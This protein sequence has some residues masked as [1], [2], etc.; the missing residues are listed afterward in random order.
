[1]LV[2]VWITNFPEVGSVSPKVIV[3]PNIVDGGLE[4]IVELPDG[5]GC[6]EAWEDGAWVPS[7]VPWVSVMKA[8]VASPATLAKFGLTPDT[9]S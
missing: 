9:A 6:V 4:R 2:I 5:S 8:A 3:G 7:K 1:M